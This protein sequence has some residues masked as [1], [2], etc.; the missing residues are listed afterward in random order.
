MRLRRGTAR[1][2]HAS[3]AIE[4]NLAVEDVPCAL[5]AQSRIRISVPSDRD[6]ARSTVPQLIRDLL[7]VIAADGLT[8][9]IL[10]DGAE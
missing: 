4:L 5:M 6:R 3:R 9:A 7:D 1:R 2:D 10:D 8:T